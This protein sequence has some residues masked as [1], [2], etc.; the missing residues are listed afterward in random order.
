MKLNSVKSLFFAVL[1]IPG[2][3]FVG[4]GISSG[5]GSFSV[6]A[7]TVTVR[8]TS[9]N[10][11]HATYRG[12]RWVPQDLEWNQMGLSTGLVRH[13]MD[14]PKNLAWNQKGRPGHQANFQLGWKVRTDW[15]IVY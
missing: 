6:G 14:G 3:V 11:G 1:L 8:R 5:N 12:G 10:I 9:R 15:K 13:K 2:L 7:Q 4:E